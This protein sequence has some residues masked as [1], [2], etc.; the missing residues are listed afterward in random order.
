[1]SF[2]GRRVLIIGPGLVDMAARALKGAIIETIEAEALSGRWTFGEAPE[3]VLIDAAGS[4]PEALAGAIANLG[5]APTPPPTLLTGAQLP[6]AL[7]R[8]LMRMPRSDVLEAPFTEADLA[9]AATPLMAAH[10]APVQG[11]PS[12]CWSVMGAVGGSGATTIAIEIACALAARLPGPRRVCLIDLNLADGAAAA[13]LGAPANMLLVR[14]SQAPDRIDASLLDA[15]VSSAPGGVDLLAAARDSH[16][17]D[18]TTPEAVL[19]ILEVACQ[20]YDAVVIDMPRHR[21]AWSLDVLSGSDELLVIS[22]LT[23]PALLAARSLAAEIET[24]LPAGPPPRIVLNRLAKRVFGPAPSMVEAERA[25]QRRAVGGVT[26]DW[27]AAAASAN[28]GGPISELRPKSRIV[29]D[30]GD[31]VDRLLSSPAQRGEVEAK[32]A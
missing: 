16:A 28:L 2:A 10:I 19:R 6:V 5:R 8:A 27:E 32:V 14:A 11:A 29:K 13:Y 24:E 30:I 15:F 4:T 21:R 3:L 23:V 20:V 25:L 9:G 17:F 31:L 12:R 26:S 7:V 18:T 1:M 22:E